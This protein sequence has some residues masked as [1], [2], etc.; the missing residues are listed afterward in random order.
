MDAP[1][2]LLASS[3]HA[4]AKQNLV[5]HLPRR[6]PRTPR[7]SSTVG[8]KRTSTRDEVS[9]VAPRNREHSSLAV[10]GGKVDSAAKERT[11]GS[12]ARGGGAGNRDAIRGDRRARDVGEVAAAKTIGTKRLVPLHRIG[13]LGCWGSEPNIGRCPHG[14]RQGHA[15]R[16]PRDGGGEGASCGSPQPA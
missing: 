13:G 1:V 12:R 14:C 10:L 11:P 4:N 9:F 2:G 5:R 3:A 7:S 8:K 6:P 16:L 15:V